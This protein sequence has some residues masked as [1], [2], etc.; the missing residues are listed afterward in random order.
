MASILIVDD[1]SS[2]HEM[3]EAVI[4]PTGHKCVF[5]QDGE[6][7]LSLYKSSSFDVVLA[8]ISMQPM[9]GITLLKQLKTYDPRSVVIM[10]T[11]YAST[12]TAIKALK[13]GAFD[14][15]KKP[16]KVDELL[17]TLDHAVEFRGSKGNNPDPSAQI[18]ASPGEQGEIEGILPG[19]SEKIVRLRQQVLKLVGSQTPALLQGETGT[20]KKFIA[21]V[22]HR[23]RN[24][25]DAPM[26]FVDCTLSQEENF[27]ENLF[28]A[29]NKGGQWIADAAGGTLFLGQVEC[30]SDE[31]QEILVSVLKNNIN[32][33]RLICSAN[34]D[35]ED[36]IDE[37]EF[38]D[39]LFY[40]IATLPVNIPPLREHST[41]IP[42]IVKA[43]VARVAISD[44]DARQIEFT[45]EALDALT[46]YG[47]PGNMTELAQVVSSVVSTTSTR[48]ID[49]DQLPLRVRPFQDWPTLEE[50]LAPKERHYVRTVLAACG[51]D[52]EKAA[53]IL[54]CDLS[55]IST[56]VNS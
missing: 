19:R 25:N 20:G 27:R 1:L 52:E 22:L 24:G 56:L 9:D 18:P 10:M 40:R 47:W 38:S 54:G 21:D 29:D 35:L 17:A 26:V 53:A 4:E 33:F 39:E 14:Y 2:I 30:L 15:I 36:M 45:D 50:Y 28:G 55:R 51:N 46:H 6:K 48:I 12:D 44:F 34:V 41:D 5:A 8:D 13:Y 49:I 3:L 7:A 43:R 42:D 11:G 32:R 31:L 37:G 16:F 23:N